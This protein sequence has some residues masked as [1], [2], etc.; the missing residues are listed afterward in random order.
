MTPQLPIPTDSLHKFLCMFGLALLFTGV[1]GFYAIY[2]ITFDRKLVLLTE[3]DQLEAITPRPLVDERQLD[4]KRKILEITKSNEDFFHWIVGGTVGIGLALVYLGGSAWHKKSQMLEDQMKA[5]QLR[6]LE[7]E[8][9]AMEA[10]AEERG[11]SVKSAAPG[12]A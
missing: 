9:S 3:I 8:V 5:L 7:L 4:R 10:A 1:L 12:D 6:K 11:A 2:T